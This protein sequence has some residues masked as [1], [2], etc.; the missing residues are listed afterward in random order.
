M[1]QQAVVAALHDHKA[2]QNE[3]RLALGA[4]W[5]DHDLVF[6]AANGQ[7]IFPNN[8]QRD[9]E[10][11]IKQSEVSRIRV[12]DHR[13]TFVTLAI[14]A[15]AP[16]TAISASVGHARTSITTDIY[17]HVMPEQ[18][19]EVADKIGAVLFDHGVG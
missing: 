5:Q 12:H 16:I 3:R 4:A 11:L 13:H 15:G 2:R 6:T 18:R 14:K 9:Y 8:L 7:P 17:A 1:L 10:R 19:V